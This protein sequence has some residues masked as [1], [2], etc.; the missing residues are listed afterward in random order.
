MRTLGEKLEDLRREF[1][2]REIQ[3]EGK[4]SSLANIGKAVGIATSTLSD[5]ENSKKNPSLDNAAKLAQFYKVP[6]DYL[7]GLSDE[8]VN[9]DTYTIQRKT[10]LSAKAIEVL[11][12]APIDV[13]NFISTLLESSHL[14]GIIQDLA[15][16]ESKKETQK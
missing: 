4:R 12:S 3:K 2:A 1:I 7:A 5:Y 8:P 15:Q 6:L 16:V 10:G 11:Y 14:H 9:M 13:C